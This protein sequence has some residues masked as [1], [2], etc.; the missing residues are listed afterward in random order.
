M[1]K[2]VT[3]LSSVRLFI[4]LAVAVIVVMVVQTLQPGKTELVRSPLFI[5]LIL[6]LVVNTLFCLLKR[7]AKARFY[8]LLIHCGIIL[9]L[10]GGA[11]NMSFRFE[12]QI[13]LE[14]DK[15]NDIAYT[16]DA[17]YRLPFSLE[18]QQFKIEYYRQPYLKL[19]L[20]TK[21]EKRE[22]MVKKNLQTHFLGYQLE[23]EQV[24][25]DF[26]LDEKRQAFNRSA[27]WNN[28][29][30][31]L[32]LKRDSTVIRK[33]LFLK[34]NRTAELPFELK[35]TLENSAPKNFISEVVIK[36]SEK[37]VAVKIAVNSPASYRGYRLY[38]T[39]YDPSRPD[40]SVLTVKKEKFLWLV[41]SGFLI[42]LGGMLLW[43]LKR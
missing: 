16:A 43:L 30:L 8:F 1:S 29:A 12:A 21:D 32:S 31:L 14:K 25:N 18:L 28:P 7:M 6:L 26:A 10:S 22:L 13:E 35:L 37:R 2:L 19:I 9:I 27:H 38:Q 17:L 42:F 3:L 4:V 24:L 15:P 41:F 23:I 40:Y 20:E 33:W 11:L 39:S 34:T 5:I 36:D